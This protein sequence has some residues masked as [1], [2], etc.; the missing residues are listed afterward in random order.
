MKVKRKKSKMRKNKEDKIKSYEKLEALSTLLKILTSVFLLLAILTKRVFFAVSFVITG[1]AG[2]AVV[3]W[4]MKVERK[5]E[6][7]E[8]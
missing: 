7:E 8:D 2:I 1:V 4:S 6:E 5:E 3:I